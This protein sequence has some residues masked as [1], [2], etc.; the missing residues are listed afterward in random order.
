MEF[1]NVAGQLRSFEDKEHGRGATQAELDSAEARL[2][3][4]FRGGY[5]QFLSEFGWVG[6]G[7]L[8]I[9]GLGADVPSY[10]DLVELTLSE[11]N[12]MSPALPPNLIP[13][14][15]D[16][17]GNQYCLDA[18]AATRRIAALV[19]YTTDSQAQARAEPTSSPASCSDTS[20]HMKMGP[21][22]TATVAD[23]ARAAAY[24]PR[25][26]GC[27]QPYADVN[28]AERDGYY[29]N[30]PWLEDQPIYHYNS[31]RNFRV[32]DRGKF[33][34]TKPVSLLYKKDHDGQLRLVGAMY[35]TSE[36]AAPEDLDALLPI[37][38]AHWHEHVNLCYPGRQCRPLCAAE[39]RRRHGVLAQALLQYHVGQRMRSS[40]VADSCPWSSAGW[41]MSTC[42]LEATIPR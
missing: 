28:V 17:G 24:C 26:A 13:I 1:A 38:M 22:R 12:E 4:Q 21:T 34:V 18:W 27:P 30:M 3:V 8:E 23:S 36:S 16:G 35:A 29:R 40:Q 20:S 6:V 31:S 5:R 11:R 14:H 19:Q 32:A 42:S 9:F 41:H 2:G 37:S 7:D 25:R 33:D 15:N 10:L 39:D